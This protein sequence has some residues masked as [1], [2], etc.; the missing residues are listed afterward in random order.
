MAKHYHSKIKEREHTKEMM[1]KSKTKTTW[2]NSKLC[3]SM[4][5]VNMFFRYSNSF[6][7]IDYK[8]L[9]SHGL[10]SYQKFNIPWYVF[11]DSGISNILFSTKQSCIHFYSFTQW[12]FWT[13]S[14]GYPYHTGFP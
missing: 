7:V 12:P 14:Q 5:D 2:T 11:H 10:F 13:S 9:L 6:N 3:I 8:T 4:S 1:N